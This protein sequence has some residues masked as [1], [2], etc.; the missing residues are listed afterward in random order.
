MNLI[1]RLSS[2]NEQTGSLRTPFPLSS[3][4]REID[5]L[6]D[7]SWRDLFAAE[8]PASNIELAETAWPAVDIKEDETLVTVKA[9]VPGME[10][11]DIDVEV[12]DEVLTIRGHRED[13]HEEKKRGRR[14]YERKVGS[15][16]RSFELPSYVDAKKVEA[17][18]DQGVLTV[19]LPKVPG[20]SPKKV[21]VKPTT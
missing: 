4:R 19:T 18:Y 16:S 3:L 7:R 20:N 10:A 9:D 13:E 14:Y 21:A 12:T 15:F 8:F 17:K 6:F 11:K 2:G 5:R 1:R